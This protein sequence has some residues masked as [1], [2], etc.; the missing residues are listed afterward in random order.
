VGGQQSARCE[1]SIQVEKRNAPEHPPQLQL[2][3]GLSFH[4]SFLAKS[5]YSS[6]DETTDTTLSEHE[7]F[8]SHGGTSI[9]RNG[10]LC[11]PRK[12]IG[13]PSSQ[14]PSQLYTPLTPTP[15]S[16]TSPS[17]PL[18][19]RTRSGGRANIYWLI[20]AAAV[21]FFITGFAL[22]IG[23]Y[24]YLRSLDE[25]TADNQVWVGRYSLTIAFL[26][27]A[28]LSAAISM[29]FTQRLWYSLQQMKR[30]M[31]LLAIDSLFSADQSLSALIS[32]EIWRSTFI[33]T[34]MAVS[35]WLMPLIQVVAPTALTI[36]SLQKTL[37][38]SHCA[39][40]LLQITDIPEVSYR[41]LSLFDIDYER[42]QFQPSTTARYIVDLTAQSGQQLGWPSPCGSNCTYEVS[43]AAP[44]WQCNKTN[45]IGGSD[46]HWNEEWFN[47]YGDGWNYSASDSE[48]NLEYSP[49]YQASY[50][51]DTSQFWVGATD[52]VNVD[53]SLNMSVKEFLNLHLYVCDV[54]TMIYNLR[55]T[56][57]DHQQINEII[58]LSY[59]DRIEIPQSVWDGNLGEPMKNAAILGIISLYSPLVNLLSGDI[60]RDPQERFVANTSIGSIPLLVHTYNGSMA[61]GQEDPY[62]P[63]LDIGPLLEKLSQNISI[64]L[65]S[66]PKL[67]TTTTTLTTCTTHETLTVWKFKPVPLIAAYLCAVGAA[68]MSLVIGGLALVAT[69]V[70]RDRSF[71]S[72]VRSTRHRDLDVLCVEN[73]GNAVLPS[74]PELRKRRFRFSSDG[75]A[76]ARDDGNEKRMSFRSV[77]ELGCEGMDEMVERGTRGSFIKLSSMLSRRA[78]S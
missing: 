33:P 76:Y 70:A 59:K 75:T 52:S 64:S 67:D 31:S 41:S 11:F 26:V 57:I 28:S 65:L 42:L 50:S 44:A 45:K 20:P 32:W 15:L 39:V 68:T 78:D 35:I 66:Q 34:L 56:Y 30:G 43:F 40:P 49:I 8:G 3:F 24:A 6:L 18:L 54:V 53:Y 9:P 77:E 47:G 2:S 58:D 60:T 16:A 17:N 36:G 7:R 73:D 1:M 25:I 10:P 19:S 74:T 61:S 63:N 14:I 27:K 38:N 62:V 29:A 69:G 4:D 46:A 71:S 48:T 55:V 51:S 37:A 12:P 21:L 22:A 5:D 23:H 13:A 72:I